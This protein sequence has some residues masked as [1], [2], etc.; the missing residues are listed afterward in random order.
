MTE[1]AIAS[2]YTRGGGGTERFGWTC[3]HLVVLNHI[4]GIL[5]H[6]F[7]VGRL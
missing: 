4:F 2:G 6:S 7:T 5:Q 1:K 3:G